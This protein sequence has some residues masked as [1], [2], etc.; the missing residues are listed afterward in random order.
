[1]SLTDLV[2]ASNPTLAYEAVSF[3][4]LIVVVDA[5]IDCKVLEPPIYPCHA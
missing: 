5:F 3:G 2:T 4:V 1:V